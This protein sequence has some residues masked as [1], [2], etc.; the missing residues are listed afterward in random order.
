MSREALVEQLVQETLDNNLTAEEVCAEHP[1]LICE[2]LERLRQCRNVKAQ[3]EEI[4]PSSHGLSGG[5]RE[6]LHVST[7][8]PELPGY[9][10]ES[11][12]GR[13]GMGI[14][15]KAKQLKLNRPVAIKMML[16]GRFAS[17]PEIVRFKREAEMVAT[18]RHH[19]VVQ[20][21]DVGEF[22]GRPYFTMEFM[23]GGSLATKFG[24]APQPGA[25]SAAL[26]AALRAP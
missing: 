16:A 8:L 2:V 21:Y 24:G 15:Y 5:L 3:L 18:L 14:V 13:G 9:E 22:E 10:V 7:E 4:F 11:I 20:I 19:N 26:I 17:R 25:F 1:E 6:A 23:E 12:L